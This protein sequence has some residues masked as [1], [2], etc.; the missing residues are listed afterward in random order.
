M[1]TE[2]RINLVFCINRIY[3]TYGLKGEKF[4]K[5]K[6]AKIKATKQINVYV[7]KLSTS[8]FLS[9][10]SS[11]ASPSIALEAAVHSGSKRLKPVNKLGSLSFFDVFSRI[12]K[13]N[14]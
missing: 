2:K 11:S 13:I 1:G 7:S 8:I 12:F 14:F 9:L 3:R 6:D 4:F 5:K 10:S